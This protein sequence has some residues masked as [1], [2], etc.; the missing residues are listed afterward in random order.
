MDKEA[1]IKIEDSNIAFLGSE[2]EQKI[3]LAAAQGEEAWKVAGKAEGIQIWRIE[4]FKVV[5]WPKD[6]YGTFYS[7]DSY[8]VLNTYKDKSTGSLK[9]NAHMWVGEF[10]TKDEAG[11]AA[12]KIV[13]L[14]DYLN[15]D[16]ILFR[17]AQ[18]NESKFFLKYFPFIQILNGGVESGF[19]RVPI[20]EYKPRLL[21]VFGKGDHISVL[22]VPLK[23]QSLNS[24][25]V[26]ILD[27]GLTIFNWRGSK[28]NN[29]EKFKASAICTA[30]DSERNGKSE[31]ITIEEGENKEEFFKLLEGDGEISPAI[32]RK[33][34]EDF[35]N[36]M[37]KLSDES[38]QLV[39]SKVDYAKS[40]LNS[41][42]VFIID[43]GYEVIVWI[44]KDTSGNERNFSFV[45]A[46][47]Y[48]VDHGRP[49]GLPVVS[50][51]EG[52]EFKNFP[53]SV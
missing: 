34:Q 10:T 36:V 28:S 35:E 24:G 11:T 13:E 46:Q 31:I 30:L 21:H 19:K 40:S 5:P 9:Y 26:F 15:K 32:E 43:I 12:Y 41:K 17:E 50:V 3:R 20:E 48:L 27:A 1:M 44:G 8:I 18:G 37:Y 16:P 42:D 4:Q 53:L 47:K 38:G 2:L 22:E 45:L 52:K 7:G 33:S 23:K 49:K 29:F 51:L 39:M 6:Q 14:D 25:D